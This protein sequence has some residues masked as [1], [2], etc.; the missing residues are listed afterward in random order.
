MITGQTTLD[1]LEQALSNRGRLFLRVHLD[2]SR[3]PAQWAAQVNVPRRTHLA[4]VVGHGDSIAVAIASLVAQI[5][6][7]SER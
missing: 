6:G 1:E 2:A 7:V 5:D 4:R 3:L